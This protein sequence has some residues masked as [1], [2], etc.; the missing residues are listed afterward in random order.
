MIDFESIM[1][2]ISSSRHQKFT[3]VEGFEPSNNETKTRGLTTWLHP[4]LIGLYKYYIFFLR[5]KK[6]LHKNISKKLLLHNNN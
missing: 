4:N 3:R 5:K 6:I 2:T 1:F